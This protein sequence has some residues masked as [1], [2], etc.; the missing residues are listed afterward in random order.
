VG[1]HCFISNYLMAY[2]FIIQCLVCIGCMLY[3]LHLWPIFSMSCMHVLYV[4]WPVCMHNRFRLKID[5]L[6]M[7]MWACQYAV[8][9]QNRLGN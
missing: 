1:I 6:L 5:G 3:G 9:S 7:L 2:M 8:G 4:A